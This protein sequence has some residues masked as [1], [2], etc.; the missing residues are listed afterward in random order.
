LVYIFVSSHLPISLTSS[1]A[2]FAV[3]TVTPRYL[4]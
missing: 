4:A 2:I 3:N 1:P